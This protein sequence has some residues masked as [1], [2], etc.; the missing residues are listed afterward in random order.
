MYS[1]PDDI[2]EIAIIGGGNWG[3]AVARKIAHNLLN[4]P[5]S[6]HH[7]KQVTLWIYEEYINGE[8]L[9]DIINTTH[10]NVKYLPNIILPP[11]IVATSNLEEACLNKSILLFVIPH[12]FLKNILRSMKSF[13]RPTIEG[14]DINKEVI[15]VSLIKGVEAVKAENGIGYLFKRYTEIINE[16][17]GVKHTVAVMG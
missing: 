2:G 6:A 11:N 4:S 5:N 13:M 16:E 1:I 7:T 12:Q 17:L 8:S 14:E 9:V 3:T 15:C 10:T